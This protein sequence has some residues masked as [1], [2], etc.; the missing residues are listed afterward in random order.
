MKVDRNNVLPS[1]FEHTL[2]III[3]IIILQVDE[4]NLLHVWKLHSV[5]YLP[6][7]TRHTHSGHWPI[8]WREDNKHDYYS[9]QNRSHTRPRRRCVESRMVRV[10]VVVVVVVGCDGGDG[11]CGLRTTR[12][13]RD[14][15]VYIYR[16]ELLYT[17]TN[18]SLYPKL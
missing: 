15:Q 1:S 4:R 8:D 9:H 10:V 6:Y 11:G 2:T 5:D 7:Y 16:L 14:S 18:G 12:A 3:P 17:R 13:Q